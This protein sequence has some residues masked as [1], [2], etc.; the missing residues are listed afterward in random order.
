MCVAKHREQILAMAV[1]KAVSQKQLVR[2]LIDRV[3][4]ADGLES[5]TMTK[6]T[7]A[8][9]KRTSLI[10]I[11]SIDVKAMDVYA[12]LR[13]FA[14]DRRL[15]HF[16]EM[17]MKDGE[18]PATTFP[19]D[20]AT[21]S[22]TNWIWKTHVTLAHYHDTTQHDLKR[23]FQPLCGSQV[24]VTVTGLLWSPQRVAALAVKISKKNQD[25]VA[26]PPPRNVFVHMTV[27]CHESATAVEANELP[28]LVEQGQATRIDFDDPIALTGEVSLWM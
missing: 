8:A 20:P 14:G 17:V 12:A 4:E 3:A 26:V 21:E 13:S 22:R 25:G 15:Q 23:T 19:E 2:Q 10:K 11:A 27:W 28:Q 16:W 18:T 7:D 1:D 24:T 5:Y 9:K 6:E